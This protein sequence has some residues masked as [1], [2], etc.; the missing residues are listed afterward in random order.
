MLV[1]LCASFPNSK[2]SEVSV[3]R[4]GRTSSWFLESGPVI[5]SFGASGLRHIRPT[6]TAYK[7][8]NAPAEWPAP[9]SKPNPDH[10]P[11]FAEPALSQF[12]V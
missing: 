12:R 1:F 7:L 9:L 2:R 3:Q 8:P 6:T 11:E 10:T 5:W 4:Q